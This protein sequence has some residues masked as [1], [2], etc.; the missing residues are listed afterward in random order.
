M[1][2][3]LEKLFEKVLLRPVSILIVWA[4]FLLVS[5]N[6]LPE[7]IHLITWKH[8]AIISAYF[9]ISAAYTVAC[10]I[11]NMLPKGKNRNFSILFIIDAENHQLF[12]EVKTKL[13]SEF[14]EY[15]Q[16]GFGTCFEA[17]CVEKK[18]VNKYDITKSESAIEL[19][20][21]TNCV[22][23]YNVRYS[24]DS[25][26]NSENFRIQTDYGI[27]HPAIE[28]K[29]RKDFLQTD[30]NNLHLSIGNRKFDKAHLIDE[31]AFTAVSLNII[32]RYIIGLASLLSGKCI[33]SYDLLHDIYNSISLTGN[34]G[35]L[36]NGFYPV[37][38]NRLFCSCMQVAVYYQDQF[39][40]EKDE[41]FLA[42]MDA[43]I[44][45]ANT[46]FPNTYDYFLMKAYVLVAQNGSMTKVKHC[47]EMCKKSNA[48]DNWKYSEAFIAAYE[49]NLGLAIYR[50][51]V[52][53]FSA[54]QELMRIA[55]YIEFI[56]DKKP[57][58]TSLHLAAGLVYDKI[59][60][61]SLAKSHFDKYFQSA[62]DKPVQNILVK[63]KKWVPPEV[64]K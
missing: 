38:Q 47:I 50:K 17:I 62:T 7:D 4:F 9:S 22:F 56:L 57:E 55:V 26:T 46:L 32:C 13:V 39:Y 45:E 10:I 20:E 18:R 8:W 61:A 58:L 43:M 34:T 30:I 44:E 49:G 27:I 59:G 24:V 14:E 28:E 2:K 6:C 52:K 64:A 16:K 12:Q 37:L 11:R 31:M 53:A 19:L 21:I 42:K 48:H 5:I 36:P 29:V 33:Q 1:E 40:L 41:T 15:S 3:V 51:Y 60:D 54:D 35:F 23:L 25:V 63:R